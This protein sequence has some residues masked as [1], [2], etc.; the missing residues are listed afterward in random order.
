MENDFFEKT[1][2]TPSGFFD[3]FTDVHVGQDVRA[4]S[5]EIDL[6]ADRAYLVRGPRHRFRPP[7]TRRRRYGRRLKSLLII[8]SART[9]AQR[10]NRF[11]FVIFPARR[12]DRVAAI[13]NGIAAQTATTARRPR[14]GGAIGE[15]PGSRPAELVAAIGFFFFPFFLFFLPPSP[16]HSVALTRSISL[17][18]SL[19]LSL[20]PPP[21]SL[22]LPR[23]ERPVADPA[24]YPH[25][26]CIGVRRRRRHCIPFF[27]SYLCVRTAPHT[28]IR[29]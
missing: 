22:P 15:G 12:V 1:D 25:Y 5:N 11:V 7:T 18:T 23:S 16:S 26:Y 27:F 21:P 19:T 13:R 24:V 9:R 6:S 14:P 3:G 10:E 4:R 28:Y 29:F 8:I 20:P 17:S 2:E